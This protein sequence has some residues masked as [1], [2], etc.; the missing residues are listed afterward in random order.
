[1]CVCCNG[2]YRPV[3]SCKETRQQLQFF[4]QGTGENISVSACKEKWKSDTIILTFFFCS[5]FFVPT[6]ASLIV[7]CHMVAGHNAGC[8]DGICIAQQWNIGGNTILAHSIPEGG[9]GGG[10]MDFLQD[11]RPKIL[12]YVLFVT[13]TP[14]HPPSPPSS[15]INVYNSWPWV[16][17]WGPDLGRRPGSSGPSWS[18]SSQRSPSSQWSPLS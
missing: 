14:R 3:S 11:E 15:P 13:L 17:G 18:P 12:N 8:K 7:K 6:V 2:D 9:C 5:Q 1:M 16:R 10:R 4:F